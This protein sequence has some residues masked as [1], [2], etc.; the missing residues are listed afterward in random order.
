VS[1]KCWIVSEVIFPVQWTTISVAVRSVAIPSWE[2]GKRLVAIATSSR[3]SQK[4][5]KSLAFQIAITSLS[6]CECHVNR[7]GLTRTADIRL[8]AGRSTP[9]WPDLVRCPVISQKRAKPR[10]VFAAHV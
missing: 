5:S 7:A 1:F 8:V 9:C 3:I 4:L 10:A 2:T 6:N